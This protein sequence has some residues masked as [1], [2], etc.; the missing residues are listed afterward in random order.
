[1]RVLGMG[2]LRDLS[3]NLQ[4]ADPAAR[5]PCAVSTHSHE[6][7]G[8]CMGRAPNDPLAVLK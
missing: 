6:Q 2:G 5:V 4:E 8:D 3:T 1:M 7:K